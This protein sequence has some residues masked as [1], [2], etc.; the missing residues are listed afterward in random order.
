MSGIDPKVLRE[1][2]GAV[3]DRMVRRLAGTEGT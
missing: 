3:E 1:L 2:L